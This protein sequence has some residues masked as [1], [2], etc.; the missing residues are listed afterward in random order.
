MAPFHS[1]NSGDAHASCLRHNW[2]N[3]STERIRPHGPFRLFLLVVAELTDPEY[4]TEA[5]YYCDI[6][7]IAVLVIICDIIYVII[8]GRFFFCSV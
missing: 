7:L 3:G 4:F 6:G 5:S 1:V 8:C 2:Q